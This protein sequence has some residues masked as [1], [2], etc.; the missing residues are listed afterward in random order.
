MVGAK[1][2]TE[3]K[4]IIVLRTLKEYHWQLVYATQ[5]MYVQAN[6]LIFLF[7]FDFHS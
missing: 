6:S 5:V 7:R 3:I 4:K 2:N 1:K